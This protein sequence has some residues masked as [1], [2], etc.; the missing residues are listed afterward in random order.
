[1][2]ASEFP[3][4]ELSLHLT[5]APSLAVSGQATE[6]PPV[7]ESPLGSASTELGDPGQFLLHLVGNLCDVWKASGLGCACSWIATI[8]THSLPLETLESRKSGY[9]RVTSGP[10]LPN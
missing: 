10:S 8:H 7:E 1:M 4:P 9:R 5:V 3:G 2:T 6:E